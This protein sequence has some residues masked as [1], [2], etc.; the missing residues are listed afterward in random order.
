LLIH[1][2]C[3][4]LRGS[5]SGSQN[6]VNREVSVPLCCHRLRMTEHLTNDIET[7]ATCDGYAG[8]RMAEIVNTNII[9]LG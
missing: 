8:V 7:F 2:C 1:C 5:I 9:E 3:D 4:A 6:R